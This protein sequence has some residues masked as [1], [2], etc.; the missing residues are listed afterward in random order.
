[1]GRRRF[2]AVSA[3]FL[4]LL[5]VCLCVAAGGARAHVDARVNMRV[6]HFDYDAAGMTAYC[7][8]S[9]PLLAGTAD[10]RPYIFSRKESGH[11]FYYADQDRLRADPL[12]AARRVA[13]GHALTLGG[14]VVAPRLLSAAAHARGDVP[15]FA[16]VEQARHAAEAPPFPRRPGDIEA[17][18]VLLDVA[19]RYPGV[20]AGDE[21]EFSSTLDVGPA[22]EA[23]VRNIFASHAAGG[24]AHYRSDG[25]LRSP[26]TI[27]PS[28]LRAVRDF[29][30]AGAAHILEGFDHLLFVVCLV[31]A[32]PRL[33]P[34]ALKI[35]GFS[36]GHSLSLAAG[37]YGA[38]PA[39][40][41]FAPTVE[42]LIA[43]SVLGSALLMLDRR[44]GGHAGA[45]AALTALVGLIHGCGLAFG[46]RELLSDSGPNIVP[47]LLSFNLGVE[48]GQLLVGAGIWLGFRL[49]QA[50]S[51]RLGGWL[52]GGVA[53]AGSAL[54]LAWVVERALPVWNLQ[55]L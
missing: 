34:V 28:L 32:D 48:A 44:G 18:D 46:L 29:V 54:S 19:L 31:L 51:A 8:L 11:V 33:R 50:Y 3:A 38:L 27:N 39:A 35:T 24:V 23:P 53:L 26:I 47:S 36:V 13:A 43:L 37:F 55:Y 20:R 25:L 40:A 14:R 21:F 10:G 15:P 5:L 41:W 2:D 42:L 7:R 1:M 16:T 49:A 52:R 6:L 45:G 12:G 9:L 30:A 17:G 4:I 22:S